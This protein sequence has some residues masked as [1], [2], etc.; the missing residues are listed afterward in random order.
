R[1]EDAGLEGLG[2]LDE[3]VRTEAACVALRRDK[4]IETDEAGLV[5]VGGVGLQL[6]EEQLQDGVEVVI[7]NSAVY[8]QYHN[9]GWSQWK[10]RKYLRWERADNG[11]ENVEGV[12]LSLLAS[13][14]S[15]EYA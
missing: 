10:Y 11:L 1:G 12:L 5:G 2:V 8:G 6:L 14:E 4:V 3:V 9:L 13:H 15:L 7:E